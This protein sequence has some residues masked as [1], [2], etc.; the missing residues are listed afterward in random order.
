MLRNRHFKLVNNEKYKL[1]ITII[2][3]VRFFFWGG[4]FFYVSKQLQS[5]NE[6]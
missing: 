6:K 2:L 5:T 3:Y 4:M 1:E